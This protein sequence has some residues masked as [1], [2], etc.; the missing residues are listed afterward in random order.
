ML[1]W[2]VKIATS[3]FCRTLADSTLAQLG[4]LGVN[5]LFLAAAAKIAGRPLLRLTSEVVLGRTPPRVT[6]WVWSWGPRSRRIH[7]LARAW[8]WLLAAM[9][10]SEPPRNTGAVWPATWLGI[11]NAPSLSASFGSPAFGSVM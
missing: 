1:D 4:E 11:G 7:S 2:P 3:M 8:C 10:R 6:M 9:A 5:R